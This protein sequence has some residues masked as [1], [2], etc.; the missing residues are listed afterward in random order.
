MDL[1]KSTKFE[2][3]LK[4]YIRIGTIR[5]LFMNLLTRAAKELH[6]ELDK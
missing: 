2:S 6:S 1:F 5:I 3:I 4:K